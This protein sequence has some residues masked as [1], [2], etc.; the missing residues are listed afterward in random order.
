[1]PRTASR[2]RAVAA[3]AAAPLARR[4]PLACGQSVLDQHASFPLGG[5]A[6]VLERVE[7]TAQLVGL[8]LP[9]RRLLVAE[10]LLDGVLA[11]R[12]D[13]ADPLGTLARGASG[14]EVGLRDGVQLECEGQHLALVVLGVVHSLDSVL[15]EV[16][17]HALGGLARLAGEAEQKLAAQHQETPLVLEAEAGHAPVAQAALQ[18]KALLRV[19]AALVV[20]RRKRQRLAVLRAQPVRHGVARARVR[21]GRPSV[22]PSSL[23]RSPRDST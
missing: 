2:K 22:R 16:E 4:A 8:L 21:Q 6:S 13:R 19:A 18:H 15:L 11:R 14:E 1:M 20:R 5:I 23:L 10:A 3:S 9:A 12:H 17:R 7:P